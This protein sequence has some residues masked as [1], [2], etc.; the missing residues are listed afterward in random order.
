MVQCSENIAIVSNESHMR[1][2]KANNPWN[3][4]GSKYGEQAFCHFSI[5]PAKVRKFQGQMHKGSTDL[6][7]WKFL[8]IIPNRKEKHICHSDLK[9]SHMFFTTSVNH[10]TLT[11]LSSTASG[12]IIVKWFTSFVTKARILSWSWKSSRKGLSIASDTAFLNASNREWMCLAH[13]WAPKNMSPRTS[14]PRS[15]TPF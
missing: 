11:A 12:A 6:Q 9:N 3:D 15:I 2:G 5:F 10:H 8:N 14:Y 1:F 4:L 13:P 7:Y